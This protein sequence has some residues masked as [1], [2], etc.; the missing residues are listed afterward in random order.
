MLLS[1]MLCMPAPESFGP[2]IRPGNIKNR[3]GKNAINIKTE[4]GIDL[5]LTSLLFSLI[6]HIEFLSHDAH[7][8]GRT[9]CWKDSMTVA[10]KS[11]PNGSHEENTGAGA[12]ASNETGDR[13]QNLF[14]GD[15]DKLYA[16]GG[17]YSF[18]DRQTWAVI[19]QRLYKLRLSGARSLRILDLGC[20]PGTW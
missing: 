9:N 7:L 13:S 8:S 16:F 1:R 20:G 4:I 5:E 12:K 18:G 2:Q 3:Y 15:L 14:D 19:E 6:T 17:R 10:F 11:V